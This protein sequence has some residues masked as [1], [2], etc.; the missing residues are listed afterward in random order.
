MEVYRRVLI[1]S[2]V[3]KPRLRKNPYAPFSWQWSCC[4]TDGRG[5]D[6]IGNGSTPTAAYDQLAVQLRNLERM[7]LLW[8]VFP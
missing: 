3:G 1:P 4:V 2:N 5:R 8:E 7:G 6:W